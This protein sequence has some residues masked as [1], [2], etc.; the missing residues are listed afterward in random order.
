MSQEHVLAQVIIGQYNGV[1]GYWVPAGNGQYMFYPM[2]TD[3][4]TI[5]QRALLYTPAEV[6]GQILSYGVIISGVTHNNWNVQTT[7]GKEFEVIATAKY[8][9]P[10]SKKTRMDLTVWR[11][12]GSTLTGYSDDDWPYVAPGKTINFKIGGTLGEAFDIDEAGTWMAELKY[13]WVS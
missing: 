6:T 4:A 8:S 12:S 1:P 2:G 10:S 3:L 11:P 9:A 13:V 5:S 7:V